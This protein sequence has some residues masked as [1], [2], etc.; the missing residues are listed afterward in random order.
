MLSHVRLVAF[1]TN[2]VAPSQEVAEEVWARPVIGNPRVR[3]IPP[4]VGS[5]SKTEGKFPRSPCQISSVE[6][7]ITRL[8][9]GMILVPSPFMVSKS[10]NPDSPPVQEEAEPRS[11]HCTRWT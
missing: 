9:S 1:H 11:F 6:N 8:F 3:E 2:A 5:N 10:S 4:P 7:K